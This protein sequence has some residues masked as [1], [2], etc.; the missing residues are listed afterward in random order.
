MNHDTVRLLLAFRRPNGPDELTAEDAAELARHLAGCPECGAVAR[1]QS[2]FD[3][4]V[5]VA[6][7]AVPVPGGLRDRLVTDALARRGADLRRRA[8]RSAVGVAAALAASVLAF[9]GYW[10]QRPAVDSE[11]VGADYN[12]R[13]EFPEQS[14]R[15]WLTAQGLPAELPYDFDYRTYVVHGTRAVAGRDAPVVVFQTWLPN[16]PNR[17]DTVEVYVLRESRFD[18]TS[19]DLRNTHVSPRANVEVVR[20]RGVVYVIVF[21]SERLDPFLLPSSRAQAK[22]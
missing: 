6:M 15:S 3:A 11:A 21:T 22:A 10:A 9:G 13:A 5:G 2:G 4:A 19:P 17:P 7:A 18:L 12:A 16:N 20:G 1:Q 14:V 8:Y